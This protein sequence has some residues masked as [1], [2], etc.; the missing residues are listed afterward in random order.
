[1]AI[2]MLALLVVA[3]LGLTSGIVG[4]VWVGLSRS[5]GDAVTGIL[6][7][8]PAPQLAGEL[9][10]H[11]TPVHN[12]RMR[13]LIARFIRRFTAAS[14]SHSGQPSA[15][16]REPGSI[17]LATNGPGWVMYLGHNSAASLSAPAITIG[18]VM[19]VLTGSSAPNSSRPTAPG[20]RGGSARCAITL[21]GT[22]TVSL[23]AWASE[24]T[25]GALMS[26]T[27]NTTEKELAALMPLMRLDL[28]PGPASHKTPRWTFG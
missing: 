23:C 18:R 4:L 16:Y 14:G 5:S 17:D 1:M 2:G 11:D 21:F 12:A 19:A 22:T 9:P 20:P 10:R 15:L 28:Q 7:A 26:P 3:G 27:A 25:I 8:E 24:H 13:H 6:L